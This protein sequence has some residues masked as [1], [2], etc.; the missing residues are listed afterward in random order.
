VV[1][2]VTVRGSSADR[3]EENRC[4]WEAARVAYLCPSALKGVILELHKGPTFSLA[5]GSDWISSLQLLHTPL[6][7]SPNIWV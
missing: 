7:R 6:A 2:A 4:Q 1:P 3:G 5:A